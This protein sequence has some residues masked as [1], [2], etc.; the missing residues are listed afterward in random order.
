MLYKYL[1]NSEKASFP[2][3]NDNYELIAGLSMI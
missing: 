2:F 1:T 3:L